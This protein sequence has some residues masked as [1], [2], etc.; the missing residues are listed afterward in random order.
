MR[1]GK[2]KAQHK[3]L[4]AAEEKNSPKSVAPT[5]IP[6]HAL[7]E[8]RPLSP[9]P[10]IV[11]YTPVPWGESSGSRIKHYVVNWTLLFRLAHAVRTFVSTQRGAERGPPELSYCECW[12]ACGLPV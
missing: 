8:P 1:D 11:R 12:Q 6:V 2:Q 4:R 3:L 10:A 7:K 5:P 9:R